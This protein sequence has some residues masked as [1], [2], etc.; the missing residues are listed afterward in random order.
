[1]D[2]RGRK[3]QEAGE[4]C[5]MRSFITFFIL[6]NIIR[7]IKSRTIRWAGNVARKGAMRY[8]YKILAGKP[9]EET[10]LGRPRHRCKEIL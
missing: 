4:D 8:V 6:P 10:P 7:V 9:E 3:W 1:M 2:L 5:I